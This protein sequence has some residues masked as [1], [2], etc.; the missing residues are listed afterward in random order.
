MQEPIENIELEAKFVANK[1]KEMMSDNYQIYD[2]SGHYRKL[3]FKDIVI[4]LRSPSSISEVFEKELS[5]LDFPAF[6]D[7]GSS[8]FDE[9]EVQTI[10]S[11]LKIIDN[12][13][14]DI[15]LVSVLRGVIGGFSDN[16]LLEIKTENRNVTFYE[17]LCE[18]TPD[19]F[20][21][22]TLTLGDK[23][24]SFLNMLQDF[25]T[26]Q[27]YLPLDELIWYI[28]DKT[29][30]Y[31]YVRLL[32]NGDLKTANLKKLFEKAKEYETASFKGLYNFINY[33]DKVSKGN[34]DAGAAKLIGENENVIRIMSIHKSK[35]LE[36]PVVFLCNTGRQFN[37][38]DLNESILL[39]QDL[40]FGPKYINY[41]RKIE[42]S[43]LAKE[44]LKVK[45]KDEIL[46]EEMR[47]LYV[48]MTRAKEKLIMVGVG[49]PD[50][51]R[52]G[53]CGQ[54][55]LQHKNIPVS[56]LKNAKSYLD[57]IQI[58]CRYN[59]D[60]IGAVLEIT[61]HNKQDIINDVGAGLDQPEGRSRPTPT[62]D[63]HR[64]N[65]RKPKSIPC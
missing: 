21:G 40:G 5:K 63:I 1:I 35:G 30:Y 44:A 16:E 22:I 47:L 17:A 36:F 3:E 8:Y 64:I 59:A 27:E 13:N 31:N 51:R 41:E 24:K 61:V 37:K 53:S 55:P 11:V 6:S 28:Y 62:T 48:A 18:Y 60:A 57:W 25:Q 32:P 19:A 54:L 14:N 38:Q 7:T 33:L 2:K 12:P 56:E 49:A 39:H 45:M 46:A 52:P 10:I 20:G 23:I 43:T 50:H 4:L 42:Y 29:G 26:K 34:Q 58:V 65:P 9:L 15:P